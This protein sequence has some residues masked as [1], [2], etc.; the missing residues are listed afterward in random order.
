MKIGKYNISFEAYQDFNTIG[1]TIPLFY[2]KRN[3]CWKDWDDYGYCNFDI[4]L[5]AL[6]W[7]IKLKFERE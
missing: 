3:F 5:H 2:I 1:L 6:C 4:I 7:G